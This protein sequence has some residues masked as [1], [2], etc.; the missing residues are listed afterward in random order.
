M[1]MAV[2]RRLLGLFIPL[3]VMSACELINPEEAIPAYLRV[4]PFTLTTTAT[5]GSNSQKITEAWLFVD[6]DFLGVYALPATIPLLVTGEGTIRLEPGIKDNGIASTPEIYPFYQPFTQTVT[7]APDQTVTLRPTTT[8]K[9]TTRFALIENFERGSHLFPFLVSGT[10]VNRITIVG[11]VDAFEGN[12]SGLLRVTTDAPLATI[13]TGARFRDLQAS[14]INVYLEVN[15]RAE[16]PVVFGL[17]AYNQVGQA[18]NGDI[19]FAAGFNASPT[20]NKIYFNLTQVLLERQPAEFQLLMQ[21]A[22]PAGENGQPAPAAANIWLDNIK[23][24]H[25]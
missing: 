16:A 7:L 25:F 23:L 13:A 5:Q 11:G 10:D 2:L 6:D 4:E 19:V 22:L 9:P 18:S 21:T 8:Y 20:W 17:L 1:N 14:N 15:Y 12:G 24:V 3:L